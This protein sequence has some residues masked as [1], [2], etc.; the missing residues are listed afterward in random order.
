MKKIIA[1]DTLKALLGESGDILS[2]DD[3]AFLWAEKAEEIVYLHKKEK[4]DL[5]VADLEM[6][7][8]PVDRLCVLMRADENL[9]AVSVIM[10]CPDTEEAAERADF[11]GAN[12]VM[13]TPV[14]PRQL[15]RRMSRL[16]NIADRDDMRE[17][18]KVDVDLGDGADLFF[19]VSV[20]IS[21]SGM[22]IEAE[23]ILRIGSRVICSFVL[24]HPVTVEAEVVRRAR[25]AAGVDSYGL[26]FI[27]ADARSRA[28]IDEFIRGVPGQRRV[29]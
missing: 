22:L 9:R 12:A 23:K 28:V 15:F 14:S 7:G 18:V 16:L 3:V 10:V 8:M 25:E 13:V 4:A 20:N 1:A 26:R 6:P 2:R 21:S 19:G 11:C 5:I 29:S 24:N 17:I 27:E